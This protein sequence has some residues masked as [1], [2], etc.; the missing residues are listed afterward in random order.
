M[1]RTDI[2]NLFPAKFTTS[3]MLVRQ[4]GVFPIRCEVGEHA[5]AGMEALFHVQPCMGESLLPP[6]ELEAGHGMVR[7][8]FIAAEEILWNY[9]PTGVNQFNGKPLTQDEEAAEFFTRGPDRIGGTYKKVVYR[10]Y[11]D[12]TFLHRVQRGPEDI[13]LGLLGPTIRAE[14]GDVIQIT[15]RN[16]AS[17][18]YSMHTNGIFTTDPRNTYYN[19][20]AVPPGTTTRYY[21]FI[22]EHYGPT[23]YDTH[24]LT[25]RYFSNVDFTRDFYDGLHGALLT[26]RKGS[27]G[28]DNRQI[29]VDREYVLMFVV[30]D[31]SET[32]YIEENIQLFAEF[33]Q[34]INESDPAFL[35]SNHMASLNGLMYGNLEG[36]NMCLKEVVSWH[37]LGFGKNTDLHTAYF[38]GN[39][40]V[41]RGMYR[42]TVAV[43]P[44]AHLTVLMKT[45]NPGRWTVE[46]R[47]NAHLLNGMRAIY[48]V[49]DCRNKPSS[50]ASPGNFISD[51]PEA[52]KAVV[53]GSRGGKVR[54]YFIAALETEWNYAPINRH[55]VTGESLLQNE[56]S[57]VYVE[58][59]DN[60][61]GRRYLKAVFR[62]FTDGRFTRQKRRE[63]EDRHLGILGPFIRAEIGDLIRVVF[64]N[65]ASRPY[66]IHPH[67]VFRHKPEDGNGEAADYDEPAVAPG[68]THVYEWEVPKRA[69]PGRKGFNCTAWAYYSSV[70]SVRDSNSG[71]VG[72]L[73]TCN[74]GVLNKYGK[75]SDVDHEFAVMFTIFNENFSWYLQR[76]IFTYT[77]NPYTVNT[78]DPEF[79]ESNRMYSV[80][81]RVYGTLDGLVM[82]YN[83]HVAWYVIGMGSDQDMHTAHFHGQTFLGKLNR[84]VRGDVVDVF[85]GIFETVE[86][87]T[88]N[89][90]TWFL[91]CHV[92]NH[93]R[94]GMS[95]V[96]TVLP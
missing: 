87:L 66:S 96:Y 20:T 57:R 35:L 3:Y 75:R 74:R 28:A 47:T 71:L 30:I 82:H 70:D 53:G 80:N 14:V 83:D 6:P 69:G 7:E 25:W 13:H 49:D 92:D 67:G 43:M 93:M 64:R 73:I 45:D 88:D 18:P 32:H 56:E 61:I 8:Y 52:Y 85:P 34:S 60:R 9:G 44:S 89:P 23:E 59:T 94:G 48:H 63:P 12:G 40:F 24:C 15:F 22:P 10:E 77:L 5:P 21:W 26:C 11:T 65:M 72:P 38:H 41:F 54:E 29:H 51:V 19:N 33:P 4:S 86:M 81:G 55:I 78:R 2:V 36:L 42:D 68:E 76:N 39:T 37:V 84:D 62:E 31:E 1:S 16:M 90:G 50:A 95:V 17:R 58:R 27:L 46:C 91:H 79:Q